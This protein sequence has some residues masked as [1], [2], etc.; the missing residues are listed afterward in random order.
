MNK[1]KI[2]HHGCS[3]LIHSINVYSLRNREYY[4]SIILDRCI[5]QYHLCFHHLIFH[6]QLFFNYLKLDFPKFKLEFRKEFFRWPT[7]NSRWRHLGDFWRQKFYILIKNCCT[8]SRSQGWCCY[9]NIQISNRCG[10]YISFQK[11]TIL[12]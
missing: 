3:N 8:S 10:S 6:L 4:S 7:W 5:H 9:S 2:V 11:L 12:T 1:D